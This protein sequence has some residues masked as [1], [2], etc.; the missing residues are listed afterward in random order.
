MRSAPKE[1]P[2]PEERAA[3]ERKSKIDRLNAEIDQLVGAKEFRSLC[4]EIISIAPQF[5]RKEE[6][7]IFLAQSY[8]FSVGSGDGLSTALSVLARVL[9]D[10]GLLSV[11]ED[12]F[13][14]VVV[15]RPV[16]LEAIE[17]SLDEIIE[18]AFGSRS[19]RGMM[20]K[21]DL[22]AK[23][24]C[25]DISDWI[26]HI[27]NAQFKDF[28]RKV[29][30]KQDRFVVAFRIP[31]VDKEVLYK[32][33]EALNDA[34]YVRTV[35]FPP[36]STEDYCKLAAIETEKYGFNLAKGAWPQI[37][38]RLA[39]EKSDGTFYGIK[40]LKKVVYELLYKKILSNAARENATYTIGA[41]DAM[42]L[43]V[44]SEEDAMNAEE[45]MN[46]LVGMQDVKKQLKE[47]LT[48]IEFSHEN[49]EMTAPTI[50]MRFVGNPG[51]GKTT[52]ARILGKV[53]K[54]KGILRIGNF[55]EYGGRDFCGR[56]VGETAPKTQT[57][58]RDAY[59]SVL[60]I[61]EAYALY[62][63]DPDSRDFGREA[64]DTLIAEMENHREDL[65]VIMAG[66]PD[67]MDILM[68]GNAG[69]RSRMPYTITFKN[70]SREELYQIFVGLLKKS[71]DYDEDVLTEA[72]AYF[73]GL[74][75]EFI[76][77]KE[78]SNGRFV[79]NLF[80]RTWAKAAMRRDL[81]SGKLR[82]I[83]E[84]FLRSI[85]DDDFKK[86]LAEGRKTKRIGFGGAKG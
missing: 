6:R 75:D 85:T 7:K 40:T 56:Y 42:Q 70:F 13:E 53:L 11:G 45:M 74:S 83:K 65:L 18:D 15:R 12:D 21:D 60:F 71:F 77:A 23:I 81:V 10:T 27:G 33:R 25:L 52:V 3:A 43:N 17:A 26:D 36:L 34:F 54:E 86:D 14:E 55:F 79:R 4:K 78:F 9:N 64:L 59:G 82:I 66:Y 20:R 2:T 31:F 68:K 67:E 46:S 63:G 80:E 38:R 19:V 35:V 30:S 8:L 58:C 84:D 57:M 29:A 62:K 47:I 24:V 22:S 39:A 28:L 1:M 48:Q 61:D 32:V 73:D 49:E 37:E 16:K 51:T 50:H 69:L 76:E 72:K 5:K 41:R 44:F